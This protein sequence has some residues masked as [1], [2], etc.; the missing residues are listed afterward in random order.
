[1]NYNFPLVAEGITEAEKEILIDVIRSGNLTM[2]KKVYE[3]E[4]LFAEKLK[5]NSAVMVNSGSSANMLILE[6]IVRSSSKRSFPFRFN[7]SYIAVP[8]IL[9]PTTL[10]PIIQLGFKALVIDVMPN[11]LEIDLDSL[12]SAKKDL[13]NK[14]V[15]AFIIH[16]LGKVIDLS[17]ITMEFANE[18]FFII[19][20]TCESLG[21]RTDTS[22]AGSF[23]IAGTF[24][25]YFSHHITTIEGGMVVTNNNDL[26]N[27]LRS[28][29]AH[30]WTRNRTDKNRWQSE[31]ANHDQ[32]FVFVTS[33]FNFRPTE[34]QG[35]LGISQLTCL[36]EFVEKRQSIAFKVAE[37]ISNQESI[38]LIRSEFAV[39]ERL[40]HMHSWMALPFI[41]ESPELRREVLIHLEKNGIQTR[42]ILAGD[43]FQQHA[44]KYGTI[45]KYSNTN[46]AKKIHETGFMLGNHHSLTNEQVQFLVACLESI[47]L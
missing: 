39:S 4:R 18:D 21:A 27:D 8:S 32:D 31:F 22:Y 16:P 1:M 17:E 44:S 19:E 6:A 13:G 15:G 24:S 42:P 11:T 41:I 2:G 9:W 34:M 35:A 43:F 28:M 25:F 29:R 12:R 46:N 20:D 47:N 10:W 26:A 14:L 23:G 38:E 7:E 45:E 40:K 33:G 37:A 5:V 30:G 3:F 36:D